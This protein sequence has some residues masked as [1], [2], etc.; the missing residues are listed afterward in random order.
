MDSRRHPRDYRLAIAA[1]I[2]LVA[3]VD[4]DEPR[5]HRQRRDR[6]R[7]CPQRR[8]PDVIA[9]D[10]GPRAEGDADLGGGAD[11]RVELL[12][13]HGRELLGIVE[14]AGDP[15][16]IEND[17]RGHHRPRQGT[18]AGLVAPRHRK[19]T[20]LDG[21]ALA[22]K[23]RPQRR[24]GERQAGSGCG[25]DGAGRGCDL[26]RDPGQI[27][28]EPQGTTCTAMGQCEETF[29]KPPIDHGVGSPCSL[30]AVFA[31][32][33]IAFTNFSMDRLVHCQR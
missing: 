6:A 19:D 18:A 13:L 10:A 26:W 24:L 5:P 29:S 14:A 33:D 12:A 20:A 9:I 15:F 7:Q 16:G 11:A 1:G 30:M 27:P 8:L 4:E 32:H 31:P 2:D 3:A 25:A 21:G 17:G 23:A 22:P 28:G